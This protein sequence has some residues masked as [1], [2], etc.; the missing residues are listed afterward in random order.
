MGIGSFF[1]NSFETS[2]TTSNI[3][4]KT[5]YYNNNYEN[6]KD[7]INHIAIS[8][9]L[10]VINT[11]NT[12]REILLESKKFE[13]IITCSKISYSETGIDIKITTHYLIGANRGIKFIDG[14]YQQLNK[15]LRF[16]RLGQ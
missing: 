12:Y 14:F 9:K 13:M 5:H 16:K 15:N 8:N 3:L 10:Q 6:V 2:D 11:D 7:A 4:L 1:S